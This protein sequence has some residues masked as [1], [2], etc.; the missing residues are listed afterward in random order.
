M[1]NVQ[2]GS[3]EV[4][5]LHIVEDELTRCKIYIL[6]IYESHGIETG[7]FK[8]YNY[9]IYSSGIDCTVGFMTVEFLGCETVN[10]I[11]IIIIINLEFAT[12]IINIVQIYTPTCN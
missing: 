6:T 9:T 12:Y 3:N 7:H 1:E 8:Y 4:G 5:K 11:I 10:E 2:R